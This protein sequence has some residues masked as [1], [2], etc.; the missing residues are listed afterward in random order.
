MCISVLFMY[1]FKK[2]MF[3]TKHL[4]RGYSLQQTRKTQLLVI[5]LPLLMCNFQY[6]PKV[7]F[8]YCFT[9]GIH[10][11]SGYFFL[12]FFRHLGFLS[13]PTFK[14]MEWIIRLH[15]VHHLLRYPTPWCGSPC[16]VKLQTLEPESK[17][18]LV[19]SCS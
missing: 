16:G 5:V 10:K 4:L 17:N 14:F 6:Y 2:V 15:S 9:F 3:V 19:S 13:T 12:L 1:L 18:L 11:K 8:F 7:I